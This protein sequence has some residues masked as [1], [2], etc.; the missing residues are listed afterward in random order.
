[1]STVE[2]ELEV[3]QNHYDQGTYLKA[4][5]AAEAAGM[6]ADPSP[7]AQILASRLIANLG[8]QRR[9]YALSLRTL[10]RFPAHESGRYFATYAMLRRRG[11]WEALEAWNEFGLPGPGNAILTADWWALKGLLSAYLRDFEAADRALDE[12]EAAA[13]THPW[14]FVQR[15]DVLAQED[16]LEESL[17]AARR[18]LE[19]RPFYRPALQTTA[20]TLECLNR[21]DEAIDLL[22]EACRH[23]ESGDLLFQLASML[24]DSERFDEARA[25]LDRVPHFWPLA[26]KD[27]AEA[28]AARLSYCAYRC[29]DEATA[30]EQARRSKS[31]FHEQVADNLAAAGPDDRRVVLDVPFVRQHHV[32]CAPATLTAIA[33]Y[34]KRPVDHLEVAEKICYDGTPA[35]SERGWAEQSGYAAREFAVDLATTKALI[36]RGVPFTF[37]TVEPTSSHLQAVVGYDARRGTILVRDSNFRA[38]GELMADKGLEH[39]RPTGPRGMVLVPAEEAARLEGIELPDAELYDRQY[40]LLCALDRFDRPAAAAAHER[41]RALDPTH[42]LTLLARRSLAAFDAD[43]VSSRHACEQLADKYPECDVWLYARWYALRGTAPRPERLAFLEKVLARHEADPIF[44]LHLA[45]ELSEDA[46]SHDESLRLLKTLTRSRPTEAR[47]YFLRGTILW[48]RRRFDEAFRSFFTAACLADKDEEYSRAYFAA[49]RRVKRVDEALAFLVTRFRRFGAKSPYPGR[50]LFLSYAALDRME[51]AAAVLEE[52]LRLRPDDGVLLLFAADAEAR[53][54]RFDL[55]DEYLRRSEGKSHP[56]TRLR[57]TAENA[58]NRGDP[59][60]ALAAWRGLL[61]LEPQSHD[62]VVEIT[63]LSTSRCASFSH[64]RC[65]SPMPF[66]TN[67]VVAPRAPESSTGACRERWVTYRVASSIEPPRRT[68]EPHAAKKLR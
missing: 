22:T 43:P 66:C 56:A 28:L 17:D 21:P 27:H 55:A 34:W 58:S 46:R 7:E 2:A 4:H 44:R 12:A 38:I 53:N 50:T 61:A 13:P 26:D 40:E 49:A 48:T 47:T 11:P 51:E 19:L 31:K 30:A 68:T 64:A 8:A 20:H 42:R 45:D 15:C 33:R 29:G 60:A 18:A 52:S 35:H 23:L 63:R 3:I 24:C 5:A 14:V 16:R 32:T 1:M 59:A 65:T 37:T 54:G 36:D 6:Y 25:H 67:V 39:Y 9:A 57:V 41:M 62:A 10:R